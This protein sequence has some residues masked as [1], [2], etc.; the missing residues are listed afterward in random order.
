MAKVGRLASLATSYDITFLHGL[1]AALQGAPV[2][3][4]ACTA[5]P[6]RKVAVR[7]LDESG[8]RWLAAVNFLLLGA[9]CQDDV[10]DEGSWKGRVG[11][12][13]LSGRLAWARQVVA[14][15]GFPAE[16]ITGLPERQAAQE[17]GQE[18]TLEHLA[19]PTSLMLGEIFSHTARLSGCPD[20]AV[21]LR[22][23]GQGLGAAIYI[24]D[25]IDDQGKDQ[26]RGRFNAILASRLLGASGARY[27]N[28]ALRREVRRATVGLEALG[29]AKETQA[30]FQVLESLTA[31]VAQPAGAWAR[32]RRR[33][34]LSGEF[35]GCDCCCVGCDFAAC[36]CGGLDCCGNCDGNCGC[37]DACNCN[38]DCCQVCQ[39]GGGGTTGEGAA[40][41]VAS[42][43]PKPRL[44][45]P[46]CGDSLTERTYSGVTID[47]CVTCQG[48]WLDHEELEAISAMKTVPRRLLVIHETSPHQA[49][50]EGTRP[51]P[52]CAKILNVIPIK[53]VQVDVCPDC[54]GIFLDQGELN[55]LLDSAD[56]SE[57]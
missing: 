18:L 48:L 41:V 46:G 42:A 57:G 12:S 2:R 8:Q 25:A 49:R 44:L 52:H 50:P 22:Q 45:C 11:L 1:L 26:Q 24:K 38:C 39:G 43:P 32:F 51:C 19:M 13:V 6:F 36:D 40:A 5:L 14:E 9:K 4:L 34:S 29:L 3:K 56:R 20:K 7:E 23:V 17:K 33:R 35:G 15:S 55:A 47:E 30:L 27:A 10:A 53:G 54:R 21:A 37:L 16:V 28:T 31:S